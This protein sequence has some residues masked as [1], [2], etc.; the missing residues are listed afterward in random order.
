MPAFHVLCLLFV[1]GKE[2]ASPPSS[3]WRSHA[4]LPNT[5]LGAYLGPTAQRHR[6]QQNTRNPSGSHSP[7]NHLVPTSPAMKFPCLTR[8]D[9][10]WSHSRVGP[11]AL[12]TRCSSS[13][14]SPVLKPSPTSRLLV[15]C[16]PNPLTGNFKVV[17][18][19][20]AANGKT[21]FS[22][23]ISRIYTVVQIEVGPCQMLL[24]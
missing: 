11:S 19:A 13:T 12:L 7:T 21:W 1:S 2:A 17:F 6:T 22:P 20:S 5:F 9:R 23:T 4:P 3:A 10:G 18:L 8:C 15:L 14:M 16:L 24:T